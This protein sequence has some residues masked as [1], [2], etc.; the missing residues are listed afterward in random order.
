M[1]TS[2]VEN[3]YIINIRM[4]QVTASGSLTVVALVRYKGYRAEIEYSPN[5]WK[6]WRDIGFPREVLYAARQ[7]LWKRVQK[8]VKKIDEILALSG[9]LGLILEFK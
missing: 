3:S 4:I 6:A 9:G 1:A 5:G 7:D 8:I 2:K